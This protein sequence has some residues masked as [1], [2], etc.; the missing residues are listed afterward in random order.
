[1]LLTIKYKDFQDSPQHTL[2]LGG[3][4]YL[5]NKMFR[6]DDPCVFTGACFKPLFFFF[7]PLA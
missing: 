5:E 3:L 2:H 6:M 1:M 7:K 4:P